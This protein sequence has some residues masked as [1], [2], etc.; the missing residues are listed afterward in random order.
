MDMSSTAGCR[1]NLVRL[2]D[3]GIWAKITAAR[4]S[5]LVRYLDEPVTFREYKSMNHILIP[6]AITVLAVGAVWSV[7]GWVLYNY[8]EAVPVTAGRW[9]LGTGLGVL[10]IGVLLY[11]WPVF[12]L[13]FVRPA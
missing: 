10:A 5:H 3:A 7:V 8:F 1:Q 6:A 13:F 9:V 12:L 11:I 2:L 4:A